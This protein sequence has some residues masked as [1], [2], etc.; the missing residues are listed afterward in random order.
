M[1]PEVREFIAQARFGRPAAAA[2]VGAAAE[3]DPRLDELKEKVRRLEADLK[4]RHHERNASQRNLDKAHANLE[5]LRNLR[6]KEA[7][8]ADDTDTEEDL[9]CH[10]TRRIRIRCG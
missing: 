9:L 3:R 2:A 1:T 7:E 10:R 4:E 8:E 5:T 6:Q